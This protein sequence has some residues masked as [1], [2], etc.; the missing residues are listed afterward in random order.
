MDIPGPV[1]VLAAPPIAR[2]D[3]RLPAL[4]GQPHGPAARRAFPHLGLGRAR[5]G[6]PRERRRGQ[7]EAVARPDGRWSVDLP[8]QPAGGAFLPHRGRPQHPHPRRRLVRRSVGRLGPVQHGVASCAVD[9]RPRGRDG[10]LR[11]PAALHR[12]QGH[13][14][15]GEGRRLRPVGGLRRLDG[16]RLLRGGVLLRPELHRALGVKVALVHS[17]WGGRPPRPGRAGRLW[18][19]SRRC[20][21]WWPTSISP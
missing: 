20:G 2:A 12:G 4:V 19:R 14:A 16:A 8:P 9:R 11:R 6:G 17:S 1:V 7:G 21:H 18:R 3:V 5:R 10:R 13:F 15:A